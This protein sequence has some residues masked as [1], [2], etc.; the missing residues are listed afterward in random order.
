MIQTASDLHL[1]DNE[2]DRCF[3]TDK[4]TEIA[5]NHKGPWQDGV[6]T[7]LTV[8]SGILLDKNKRLKRDYIDFICTYKPWLTSDSAIIS[9]AQLFE[10]PYILL[11]YGMNTEVSIS[12]LRDKIISSIPDP[13]VTFVKVISIL[14][15]FDTLRR[16]GKFDAGHCPKGFFDSRI[17]MIFP[18]IVDIVLASAK[19]AKNKANKELEEDKLTEDEVSDFIESYIDRHV[20]KYLCSLTHCNYADTLKNHSDIPAVIQALVALNLITE[21]FHLDHFDQDKFLERLMPYILE[22]G[23]HID[24]QVLATIINEHHQ[25]LTEYAVSASPGLG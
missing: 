24:A 5:N 4:F 14:M 7:I 6:E 8:C 20:S 19:K 25:D 16:H 1:I 17:Q 13:L 3:L 2:D 22:P 23:H 15:H 10:L 18:S 21:E 12:V 9:E 11:T